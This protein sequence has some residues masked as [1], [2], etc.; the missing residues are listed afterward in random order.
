[1]SIT[2]EKIL[3]AA[4]VT[5]RGQPT[6]LSTDAKGERITYASGKSI[7]VRSIDDPSSS[8][9]YTGHTAQ[10]T[11][12]KFSPSGFYIASGDVSGS[13]RVW[14]SIEAEN[15]KGEYHIISG[16]INDIAWDGDSQRII[17]VGDGRERFGHC[18]TADSGNSVGE[19]SGHSKAINSVAVRPLRPLRAATV[20]DDLAMCF[21]H[22]APFKFNSKSTG[23]HKGFVLGTAFSP[24]G[25]TLVT[26]GADKR[27][28]L[29]D[30]KTGEPT[31]SI[32]EGEH[33]GSI[34]A[35]SWAKDSKRFVTASADQTVKLWDVEAGTVVQTWRF[36]EEGGVS[37]PDQQVGVVW[38]H[39]RSD[40]LIISLSLGGD[41][42]YLVEG[43]PKSTKV[44]QGHNK[45]ITALG[46]GSDGKGNTLWTG[47]FDGRV[48]S[49]DVSSGVGTVVDGQSH[50]NQVTEFTSSAGRAYS[51]GWD[52]TLRIVDESANTFAGESLK[53]SA[54]PKGV[55]SADGKVY[56]ATVT[57]VEIYV[58]DQLA[59]TFDIADSQPTAIAAQGSLVAVGLS[60]NAVRLYKA[61]SSNKLTQ[62]HE[63]KNSTAQISALAFSKDG[64]LLAAGNTAGKIYAYKTGAL[65]VATDRWSA[66]TGRVTSIAWNEAG[67]HAVSGAL[68]TNVFV[69]S[70]AKPGSRVKTL[71][72]HKDGV[73]GVAWVDGGKKVATT[74]GDAAVKIWNVSGLQ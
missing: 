1:M 72:A 70:L 37:I 14:D 53:L 36:G 43:N 4:P 66:H 45:S 54:Q 29:Y 10:T 32:G 68:D 61:D 74:G 5:A 59:G 38:P 9:Q 55:A 48:C 67:T 31:K 69:W 22:G 57:G 2:I 63:A 20:S 6:Q 60:N 13:V 23:L 44:V 18:I 50:T 58:K 56:V 71:N 52:D 39:G 40:G 12:A 21:L 7:F 24:D 35:V 34:F 27:I 73:N 42:N 41:L 65:E 49:W 15:T 3:A 46:E 62:S 19:V 28:Q 17:A 26:V 51:V 25:N 64:S 30:G 16:R 11:V 33:T 47:S 8:K